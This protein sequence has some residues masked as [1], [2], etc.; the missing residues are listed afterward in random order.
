MPY[1]GGGNQGTN[2]VQYAKQSS[3]EYSSTQAAQL[4]VSARHYFEGK[5]SRNITTRYIY[6]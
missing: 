4:A 6:S 1:G 5:S 3:S 2:E